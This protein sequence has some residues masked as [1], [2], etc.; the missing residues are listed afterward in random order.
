MIGLFLFILS[1]MN[2]HSAETFL[3]A[4]HY[5]SDAEAAVQS[6]L[7]KNKLRSRTVTHEGVELMVEVQ[8]PQ[9]DA[10]KVDQLLSIDGVKDAPLVSYNADVS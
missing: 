2:L 4:V 5:S 8:A 6:S 7:P 1:G 3:L 9:K 10:P